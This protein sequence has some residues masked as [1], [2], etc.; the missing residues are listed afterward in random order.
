MSLFSISHLS[1]GYAGGFAIRDICLEVEPGTVVGIIGPNGSGKSTL[2]STVMGDL[3]PMSGSI[4]LSEKN[5]K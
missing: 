2:L 5:L 4:S 1:S 3:S